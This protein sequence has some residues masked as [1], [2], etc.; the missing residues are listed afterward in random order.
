MLPFHRLIFGRMARKISTVAEARSVPSF[1]DEAT[2]Y[3]SDPS[4]D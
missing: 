1:T 3:L 2:E 4:R